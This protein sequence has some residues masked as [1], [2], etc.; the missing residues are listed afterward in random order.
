M[1]LATLLSF[2]AAAAAAASSAPSVA[3]LRPCA[4]RASFEVVADGGT[5]FEAEI[6]VPRLQPGKRIELAVCKALET[7]VSQAKKRDATYH[8]SN[9][10]AAA[11]L[12]LSLLASSLF[13]AAPAGTVEVMI[14]R[15]EDGNRMRAA[16]TA[17]RGL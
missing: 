13:A 4:G 2:V 14:E 7:Q 16:R 11:M 17:A 12:R 5:N 3:A 10:I 6:R 1:R 9:K 8:C 15:S